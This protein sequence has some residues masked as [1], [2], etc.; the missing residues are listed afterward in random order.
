MIVTP[1]ENIHVYGLDFG[2]LG[3]AG[4]VYESDDFGLI[5][6]HHVADYDH[7]SAET[8]AVRG[9]TFLPEVLNYIVK[10]TVAASA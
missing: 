5:G 3:E 6:V 4:L 2:S 1:A 10:G 7:A 9:A 8:Y